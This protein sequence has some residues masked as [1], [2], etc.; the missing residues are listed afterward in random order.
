MSCCSDITDTHTFAMPP[1][2]AAAANPSWPAHPPPPDV[3][4]AAKR[5][6]GTPRIAATS[7]GSHE[8]E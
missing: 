4:D 3:S 1:W 7:A 8:K 6:S 2:I 5:T